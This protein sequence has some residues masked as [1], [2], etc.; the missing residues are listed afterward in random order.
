MTH[1]LG[2]AVYHKAMREPHCIRV[3]AAIGDYKGIEIKTVGDSFMIVFSTADDAIGC[4]ATIQRSLAEPPIVATD[5]TGKQWKVKVRIGVH[6][7]AHELVPHEENGRFD[8]TGTDVN[9][10]A[11]IEAL[12]AGGQ[13]IVSSMTHQAAIS[14]EQFTWHEWP[15]RRIK[16]FDEPETVWELLWD[17]Q[18]RGEPG[19]H[20]LCPPGSWASATSTSHALP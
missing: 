15:G 8:Y 5:A 3:R 17:G 11:R 12:G 18:T 16:S 7:A 14:P 20:W 10:T 13:V 1:A 2:D 9:F 19:S 4:A 6:T